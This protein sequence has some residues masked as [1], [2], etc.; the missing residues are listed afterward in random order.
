MKDEA[1][2]PVGFKMEDLPIACMKEAMRETAA[3]A[4]A[5]LVKL[6]KAQMAISTTMFDWLRHSFG[7]EKPKGALADV[8]SL[9]ADSF[10]AAVAGGLPKKHKLTAAEI[11]ELKRE[12]AT[13]IEPG[14]RSR[15]EIVALE[16]KLSKLVNEA[17]GLSPT[18]IELM[19]RTAP[20]RMPL[21]PE[22]PSTGA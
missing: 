1:L 8:A 19:W 3:D 21:R 14:R 22:V 4:A 9:D 17:Y 16:R 15:G 5:T 6:T 2:S 20:P 7:I 18:E 11:G 10:V 13:T 12:H